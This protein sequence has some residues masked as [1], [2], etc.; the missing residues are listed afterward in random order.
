MR[1]RV[2]TVGRMIAWGG[3]PLGAAATGL[4]AH[5]AGVRMAYLAAA[6]LFC[7]AA[8]VASRLPRQRP[9]VTSATPKP[10]PNH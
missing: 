10:H 6:G 1:S 7:L 9:P 4:I 8:A 5:A 2:M 3:Q